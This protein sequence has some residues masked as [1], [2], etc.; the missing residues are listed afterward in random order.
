MEEKIDIQ[1]SMHEEM[2]SEYHKCPFCD[3][4]F[5]KSCAMGGHISQY[6]KKPTKMWYYTQT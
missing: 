2:K 6:H 5:K 4:Q 3:K 1:L